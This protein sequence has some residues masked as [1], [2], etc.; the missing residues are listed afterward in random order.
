MSGTNAELFRL[1]DE[2]E[3]I[4]L[5]VRDGTSG[6]DLDDVLK[7]FKRLR[8]AMGRSAPGA[9]VAKEEPQLRRSWNDAV[10]L[11]HWGRQQTP[12]RSTLAEIHEFLR[13]QES[14]PRRLHGRRL[15]TLE[16]FKKYV[17][18]GLR[19]QGTSHR[20]LKLRA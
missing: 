1:A 9:S 18:R 13:T 14:R 12:K 17:R 11:Y 10:T 3:A 19:A 20:S 6:H 15:P 16:N 4:I 8:K 5:A 7:A 2:V